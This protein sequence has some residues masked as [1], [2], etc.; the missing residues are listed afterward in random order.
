MGDNDVKCAVEPE[1]LWELKF[2]SDPEL[3][4]DGSRAAAK[5]K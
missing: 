5:L 4:K 3:S 2:V 1:D